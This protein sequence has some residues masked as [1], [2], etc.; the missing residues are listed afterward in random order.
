MGVPNCTA[1]TFSQNVDHFGYDA[2]VGKYDQRY[3]TYDGFVESDPTLVTGAA[4]G[5]VLHT[6]TRQR[7][8]L[9]QQYWACVVR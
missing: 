6:E 5:R 7:R 9:C 4:L 2:A 1:H 8:A 3:F